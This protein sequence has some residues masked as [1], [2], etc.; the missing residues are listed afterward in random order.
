MKKVNWTSVSKMN[1]SKNCFWMNQEK[2]PVMDDVYAEIN[3]NFSLPNKSATKP[4]AGKPT[5]PLRVL[6]ASRAQNL[7]ILL[8]V[9]FKNVPFEQVKNYIIQCDTSVLNVEFNEGLVKYLP[10]PHE[11]T[12]LCQLKKDKIELLDIEGFVASL[13]D[14]D[15]LIPRLECINFKIQYDALILNLEPEI[16]S[17][18][19][20]CEEVIASSN[21]KKVLSIV[22]SIGNFMNFGQTAK[23]NQAIGFEL[24][25]LPK[26]NEIQTTDKKSTLLQYIVNVIKRKY[27][28]SWNF[29]AELTHIEDASHLNTA[30][31]GEI[32]KNILTSYKVLKNELEINSAHRLFGDEF[33]NAMSP[34]SL[35]C[36]QQIDDL[37][38]MM[39]QMNLSYKKVGDIYAFDV[40]KCPMGE[41]FSNINKFE[42]LFTKTYTDMFGIT[43]ANDFKRHGNVQQPTFLYSQINMEP[44]KWSNYTSAKVELARLSEEGIVA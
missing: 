39:N 3:Q 24:N 28:G 5:I 10:A 13:L 35:K 27:S 12:K 6:D 14:I 41:F 31:I 7:L 37:T 21:F 17:G 33:V 11:M 8:R 42:K 43:E 44:A 30:N 22:L 9:A 23:G 38:T 18:I 1:L 29:G 15:R 2:L 4:I 32:I 20:A 16:K 34:F 19:A 25:I 36:S 26:L 40:D